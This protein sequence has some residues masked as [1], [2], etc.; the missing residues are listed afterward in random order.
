MPFEVVV[1]H[2]LPVG[3]G[4]E[5]AG[6]AFHRHEFGERDVDPEQRVE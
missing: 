6:T 2:R 4:R 5:A 3:H 1:R